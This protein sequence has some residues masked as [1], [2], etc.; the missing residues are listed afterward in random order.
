MPIN[1]LLSIWRSE[2]TIADNITAWRETAPKSGIFSPFPDNL[3]PLIEQAL[4]KLGIQSLY[5]HQTRAWQ[6]LQNG[7]NTIIATGTASGK[8]LCY[9]LP[10]I[11]QLMIDP[12][13]RALYLYP[14]KALAQD[15]LSTLKEMISVILNLSS[16]S[17]EL[18]SFFTAVYDGDT[19]S[20]ARSTI[21]KNGRIVISNPDM[22]HTAILPHHTLWAEFFQNLNFIVLDEAHTYR[23][24]FGSH[25]SNVIRRLKR[26]AQF[27]N[28]HPLFILSSAT[29][30]NPIDL[31]ER[32][33]EE[34]VQLIDHDSS[35]RGPRN[36]LI[37]NPPVINPELGLR[38]SAPQESIRL[39]EDLLSQDIQTLIFT[40]SR[41][42]VEMMLT[43][44]RQRQSVLQRHPSKAGPNA[45]LVEAIRGYRS[46]YLAEKR[47]D[48]EYG[49][50]SGK[51][52]TVISTNALE[53][54]IDIGGMGAVILVGYPG[55]ISG[56]IQQAG[57]A[58]R[59][60]EAA[61]AVLVASADPL[62]QFLAHHPDYFFMRPLEHALIDP[63][64]L[65][66]ILAHIR[67]AAFELPFQDGESFGRV[68]TEQVRQMLE[69][70]R[71]QGELHYSKGRYFWMADRYPA[72]YISL[73][74]ASAEKII[75]Q[76]EVQG[77]SV[78]IGVVDHASAHWMVHPG[79]I[80]LHE[81]EIYRVDALDL[82]NKFATLIL[83]ES[84]Y[85][86]EPR[87][88]T[89]FQ[90]LEEYQEQ[91]VKGASK[92]FGELE[93]TTQLIG[94][95]KIQ[96]TTQEFLGMEELQLPPTELVTTGYWITLGEDTVNRLREVQM[97]TNDPNDYG[98]GWKRQSDI[99]HLRDNY[100]CQSCGAPESGRAHDVH[101]RIPFRTF[102]DEQGHPDTERA[103][104]IDNL[105]TLCHSCHRRVEY[106]VRM[107]SGLAGLAYVL[108]HLAPLH[109]MCDRRDIGV[110]SDPRSP[111]A[112]GLP[113][114]ILYD[115]IPAGIGLSQRLYEIHNTILQQ[116][117]ELI[118]GCECTNGCPSCV[119]PAGE[120]GMGGKSETL[121][122]L[123]LIA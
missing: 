102:K 119:G 45:S 100:R 53:L 58:G 123:E 85:Y 80:Y 31:A 112:D 24:V 8:T 92:V 33:I 1:H 61:L 101:H 106:A 3:N 47:R 15:Q 84:D 56:T 108:S 116:A 62:D 76:S 37:Y 35:N 107:R 23:G 117:D 10:V 90:L 71:E 120:N 68:N 98:T 19:P 5:E 9:N 118:R 97:W 105:I 11:N 111:L 49:L 103:N 51:V 57:R 16:S 55:T 54:G 22:L 29:I 14:T 43:Y 99:V 70:L 12:A 18:P 121:A 109:L 13:S 46:G 65:L 38:R 72:Q 52:R 32:L 113:A 74:S 25:V 91:L 63:N 104:H 59:G 40:R 44:L 30:A 64:N 96:W 36:F 60:T 2:P 87:L 88:E 115:Q 94:Y 93:V 7:L 79:A 34:P 122:I 26:I 6:E 75:L 42:S 89:T 66:I 82:E 20:E 4:Q 21:R 28:S 17:T 50:R 95:R 110:N 86:T 83:S 41:R 77:R 114:V 73:R 78:T 67:C 81:G 39:A 27:Y 69:F 48:V